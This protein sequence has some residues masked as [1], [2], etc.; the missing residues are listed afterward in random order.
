MKITLP[1]HIGDITLEQHQRY[2]KLRKREDL[3]DYNFNKRKIEIFTSLTFQECNGLTQVDYEEI[4]R[5]IDTALC[6]EPENFEKIFYIGDVKMGFI[7]N[8][9]KMTSAEFFD[10]SKYQSDEEEMH[11]VMAIL[12]RP[13]IK[14]DAFGNYEIAPYIGTNDICE[15]MKMTPLNIVK[16]AMVFFSNLANELENYI[17]KYTAEG[18]QKVQKHQSI[19]QSG[20]GM[21]Q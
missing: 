2:E 6:F 12:Y 1:E 9:E 17:Q 3:D 19:L 8:L 16:G 11:R 18:L 14:E 10:L 5:H 15:K 4:L 7:P 13:V 20:D 21:P